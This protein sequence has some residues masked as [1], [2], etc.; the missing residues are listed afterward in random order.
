M[1][2]TNDKRTQFS[3]SFKK[4]CIELGA[5][6]AIIILLVYVVPNV[7]G[8]DLSSALSSQSSVGFLRIVLG[9]AMLACAVALSIRIVNASRLEGESIA[10]GIANAFRSPA[11]YSSLGGLALLLIGA[12][13]LIW[14][15]LTA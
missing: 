3:E 4:G 9:I 8:F 12:V 11:L 5:S 2:Q 13:L 14:L 6:A 1:A 15:G 10:S 7:I